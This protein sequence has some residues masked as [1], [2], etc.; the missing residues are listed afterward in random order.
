MPAVMVTVAVVLGLKAV[1]MA[2]GVAET[3]RRGRAEAPPPRRRAGARRQPRSRRRDSSAMRGADGF[4]EMAGLSAAEVQV[5]QAL[6]AP[7]PNARCARRPRWKR[8]TD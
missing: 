7:P 2:Q 8:K 3:V 6:G 1:A 4:A 5:L